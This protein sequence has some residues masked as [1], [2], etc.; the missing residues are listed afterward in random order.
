[1]GKSELLAEV[2]RLKAEFA[3][4]DESK[5]KVLDALIK[6]A[7]YETIYLRRMNEQALETGLVEVHPSN[8]RMQ[9][10]LPVSGE[11][12]K[13]AA[14]LTNILDKLCKHL[15]VPLDEEE[16]GLREFE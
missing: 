6:Q 5:I 14:A 8:P 9:R 15:A 12:A 13:H 1:M 4:A 10:T 7:A 3:G 11:I 16:S 2:D